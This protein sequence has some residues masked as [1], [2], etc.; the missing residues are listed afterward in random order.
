MRNSCL[1][2]MWVPVLLAGVIVCVPACAKKPKIQEL[3]R[4]QS[5]RG[6]V[7]YKGKPIPFGVV[8]FYS[9]EKSFDPATR[10]ATPSG[11]APINPDG[12]YEMGNAAAGP[13][14]VCIGTDPDMD[15]GTMLTPAT[16]MVGP[17][18]P[19]V[20]QGGP[21]R[22]ASKCTSRRSTDGAPRW[23]PRYDRRWAAGRSRQWPSRPS[24]RGVAG[25]AET[26]TWR[27]PCRWSDRAAKPS[28]EGPFRRAKKNA[29]RASCQVR[30][31]RKV[32]PRLRS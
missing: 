15:L 26:S 23:T 9:F 32:P 16:M 21:P 28:A 13:V 8:L 11:I 29:Q 17:R 10:S 14:M 30:H 3:E 2:R 12:T 5:V 20:P 19:G 31:C 6:K 4:G 22:G 24:C 1:R 7:T 27:T 18:R 25:S